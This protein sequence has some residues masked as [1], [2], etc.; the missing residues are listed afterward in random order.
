MIMVSNPLG[1][2]PMDFEEENS[3]KRIG[4]RIRKIRI[5]RGLSQAELGALIGLNADRVQKYENGARKPKIDML[6]Q[7]ARSLGVSTQ[8]LSDP[9]TATYV[10]AMFAMFELENT[11][12][13][14]I[15]KTPDDQPPGLC[16]SVDFRDEMYNYMEEW[17]KVYC[18]MQSELEVATSDEEKKQITDS[19]HNW[20][21]TFPQGIVDRTEKNLKKERLKKKIAELQKAYDQLDEN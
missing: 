4:A 21:W 5:A 18:Q 3:A 11:F 8:A 2:D 16:L 14:K 10:G 20:E 15:S 1:S 19:Y 9:I 12:N 17:Y 13:M 6:K 7:I